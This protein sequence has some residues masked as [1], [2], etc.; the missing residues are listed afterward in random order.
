MSEQG[1]SVGLLAALASG[2]VIGAVEVVLAISFAALVFGGY[3]ASFLSRGIGLYLVAA[4]VT[5]AILA[6][7]AG[8]RGVV[9]SVQDA[10]AAVLAVVAT[11][12]ALDAFGS[13]DRAFLTVVA[14]TVVVTLSTG[15]A[16]ALLGIF[17]LGNLVRYVPYPVVGGFLAGTGWLLFKGGIGVAASVQPYFRTIDDLLRREDLTRWIPAL[18]FGVVLLVVSRVVNRPLVIPALMGL[19]LVL[20]AAGV[21]VTGSSLDEVRDGLWLLGPFPTGELWEPRTVLDALADADW[22]AVA[23]QVAGIA[24]AIFVAVIAALFNVSGIELIRHTDLDSNRELRDAGVVNVVSSAFGG[25]PGY[26]ALSLTALAYQMGVNARV[27]GLV[28][29]LVPLT[30]VVFGASMIEL[31]LA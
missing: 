11:T 19:G 30:A 6:W 26:H 31:S 18:V 8:A 15:I 23:G 7:R 17:R 21:L 1:R 28:A 20:F 27:A 25:I 5:L 22:S 14:A 16:F 10:A 9:G 13:L 29:A 12:T 4:A 2:L 24:T 3:L